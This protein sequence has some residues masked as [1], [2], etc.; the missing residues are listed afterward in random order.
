MDLNILCLA[1]S[2]KVFRVPVNEDDY[3]NERRFIYNNPVRQAGKFHPPGCRD[4]P[5]VQIVF[6]QILEVACLT[7]F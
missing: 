6:I 5:V 2:I 4:S 3:A 7:L 1:H